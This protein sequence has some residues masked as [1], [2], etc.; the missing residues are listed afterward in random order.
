MTLINF[1]K[2]ILKLLENHRWMLFWV[3][4]LFAFGVY[5]FLGHT[6]GLEALY[7]AISL[8]ALNIE[9]DLPSASSGFK[10]W[11]YIA[12]L[13]AAFYTVINIISL[14][15]KRFV[16]RALVIEASQKPY[17]LVCG[18]G[19]KG[20]AYIESE[21]YADEE[22]NIIAIEKDAQNPNIEKFRA[23]GVAVEVA[24]AREKEVLEAL[25]LQNV[26]HIVIVAGEDTQNLEIAL[27][28]QDIFVWNDLDSKELYLHIEDR[29]L[30]K[31]YKDGGL[32]DYRR[33]FNIKFF[34][35]SRNAAKELFLRYP[36]DGR[37]TKFINSDEPFALVV[38]GHSKLAIEVIGQIC[39]LAH[40]PNE[41]RVT[42]YCIDKDAKSFKD[43]VEFRYKN[44][45]KIP[46]INLV[47]K[48]LD[49]QTKQF[50]EDKLWF[51]EITNIIFCYEDDKINLDI[52]AEFADSIYWQLIKAN[53]LHSKIHIAISNHKLLADGITDNNLYYDYFNIFAQTDKMVSRD[54][55][56][57]ERFETI[58]KCIHAGYEMR[59]NPDAMFSEDNILNSLWN[60]I[61]FLEDRVSSRAQAYHIPVKLKAMGLSFETVSNMEIGELLLHNQSL[62][63]QNALQKDLKKL[64][65]DRDSMI[66]KTKM[67]VGENQWNIQEFDYFPTEYNTLMEK[68]IRAEHNRWNAHHW[69]KGWNHSEV[70]DK[71]AKLH[72]CLVPLQDLPKDKRHTVIYDI[73]SILYIPNLLAKA[74]LKLVG[75]DRGD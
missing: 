71:S 54:V 75:L 61:D 21:L 11:V 3:I 47:Y 8:F 4:L 39:E 24:D 42:I 6:G 60:Q 45:D 74:G 16:N 70:K 44:I 13:L 50:Y 52:A 56:I 62:F 31:F 53:T 36:V 14:I 19:E 12:G 20:S 40:L 55:V 41:N 33:K 18:L 26:Q 72:D 27:V 17:I 73:Y 43:A 37:D 28:L 10:T 46:N 48:E 57:N 65:L 67:L 7:S 9:A 32:F 15:A 25:Q 38:V 5:K 58:A 68:L 66:E 23:K 64:G 34:S 22:A 2:T 49:Y 59:Y 1:L 51:E 63:N 30:D 35:V 69:L 29:S